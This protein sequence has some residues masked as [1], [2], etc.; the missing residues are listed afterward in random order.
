MVETRNSMHFIYVQLEK[1][2]NLRPIYFDFNLKNC[3]ISRTFL[4]MKFSCFPTCFPF[5]LAFRNNV[6]YSFENTQR[7][8]TAICWSLF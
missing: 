1:E 8:I 7:Y 6:L 3:A 2:I 4:Q 5:W